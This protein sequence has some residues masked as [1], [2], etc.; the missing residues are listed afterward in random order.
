MSKC[1]SYKNTTKQT[2]IL[3][4]VIDCLNYQGNLWFLQVLY[5]LLTTLDRFSLKRSEESLECTVQQLVD[6]TQ[7]ET[8]KHW[9]SLLQSRC[10]NF[11]RTYDHVINNVTTQTFL[12]KAYANLDFGVTHRRSDL[13]ALAYNAY[14]GLE[15]VNKLF[16]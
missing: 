7:L 2:H 16:Y 14:A 3:Y 12:L 10:D 15:K 9:T 4:N 8:S 13:S 1:F 6:L 11:I 5:N